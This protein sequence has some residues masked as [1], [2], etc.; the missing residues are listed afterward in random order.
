VQ[1]DGTSG[2][3]S[4]QVTESPAVAVGIGDAFVITTARAVD[5]RDVITLTGTDGQPHDA[6]VLMVDQDLGLA[7]LSGDAASM[8]TSYGIGPAPKAGDVVTVLGDTPTSANVGVDAS[9]KLTLD[10]WSPSTPEG[11][12]VVNADGLLVAM[13]SHGNSGNELVSV[14]SVAA[15][16]P[17]TKP[18]KPSPWLGIHVAADAHGA[19][20]IDMVG[21]N[22]PSSIVGIV[23]G[24]IVTAVDGAP[25]SSVDELKKI[26]MSHA[27]GD[28]VTLS[29]T[30][31]DQTTGD[32]TV[33]LGTAPSM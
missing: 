32:I 20:V 3:Q 19:L 11:T 17:P 7:V 28:A 22:G 8:T 26:V 31:A 12:P 10:A 14:A 23:V 16:L 18:S 15:M 5:G 13:C 29:I 25:V 4:A 33:T 9:G 1:S 24:D 21:P 30:H 27:P 2:S 6:T